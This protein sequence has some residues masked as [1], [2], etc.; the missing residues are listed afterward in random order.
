MAVSEQQR[1]LS[2]YAMAI[3]VL[4]VLI[5]SVLDAFWLRLVGKY[6]AFAFVARRLA[7]VG[8]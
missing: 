2:A 4:R 8:V 3:F 7:L 5:P 1:A 6:L